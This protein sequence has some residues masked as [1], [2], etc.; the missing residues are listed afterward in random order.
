[1]GQR[2]KPMPVILREPLPVD[3]YTYKALIDMLTCLPRS[4][5][6]STAATLLAYA[7]GRGRLRVAYPKDSPL[8]DWYLRGLG[9]S[10]YKQLGFSAP[11]Y[12][13]PTKVIP[14]GPFFYAPGC[15]LCDSSALG[16]CAK[17]VVYVGHSQPADD[18][19]LSHA[20]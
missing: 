9:E 1:M 10:H 3:A 18:K 12:R 7:H 17:C 8:A 11:A 5:A 16:E 6:P 13:D 15:C 20:H 14:V 2:F 4:V 19:E